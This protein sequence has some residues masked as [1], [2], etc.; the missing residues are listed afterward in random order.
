MVICLEFT[1]TV[2][3][4][5]RLYEFL[6][7]KNLVSFKRMFLNK[8]SQEKHRFGAKTV[9]NK[10]QPSYTNNTMHKNNTLLMNVNKHHE[11]IPPLLVANG[12]SCVG[13]RLA[14]FSKI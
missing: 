2:N 10:K 5:L 4:K 1:D 8:E 13:G 6:E 9:H 3:R 12:M 7:A 14:K 11:N